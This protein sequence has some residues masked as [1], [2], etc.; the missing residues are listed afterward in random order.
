MSSNE[1]KQLVPAF[2]RGFSPHVQEKHSLVDLSVAKF[3][4]GRS[5]DAELCLLDASISRSQCVFV[6]EDGA[7]TVTDLSSNG[8]TVNKERVERLQQVK[9]VHGDK[10]CLSEQAKFTWTF[11]LGTPPLDEAKEPPQKKQRKGDTLSEERKR[12]KETLR[13]RKRIAEVRM[14]REK[15]AL[16]NKVKKGEQRQAELL[17]ERDILVFRLES[18][19]KKQ[20]AKDRE[21]RETL[22]RETEGKVDKEEI[23]KEFEQRL[24]FEREKEE[25]KNNLLLQNMQKRIEDEEKLRKQENI[26]RDEQLAKLNSEKDELEAKFS[27]EKEEMEKHLQE[28]QDKLVKENLSRE[29]QDLEWQS[30][31]ESVNTNLQKELKKEKELNDTVKKEME[32]QVEQKTDELKRLEDILEGERATY[33][34]EM[35]MM[36]EERARQQEEQQRK[37]LEVKA[38]QEELMA[39]QE[40]LRAQQEEM[41]RKRE[42]LEGEMKKIQAA[43]SSAVLTVDEV[44]SQTLER[45]HQCPACLDLFICPVVLN[46][47]HTF[48]WLCLAQ[49]KNNNGRTR[50]DL[51]TCPQCRTAVVHENRV[52]TIDSAIDA[53]VEKL[54]PERKQ[55]RLD[56]IAERK[57][58]AEVM[59]VRS[60]FT[61]PLFS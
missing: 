17:T 7:W 35:E 42:E 29:A 46:C 21:A 56:K 55:E 5:Q 30:R 3:A 24:I 31:V 14:M 61:R 45:E 43:T 39:Q 38:Q 58:N 16:E 53:F 25:E 11:N 59:L 60:M 51:G 49:W 13:E 10:I 37:E 48:C 15:V 2:L 33:A 4:I 1:V 57:G 36:M 8:V 32:I 40:K 47:G 41:E 12:Q 18:Q 44:V 22:K 52:Y 9:L 19:V 20:A 6:F 34:G 50:G 26:E 23:M 28:L 27:K 54:G